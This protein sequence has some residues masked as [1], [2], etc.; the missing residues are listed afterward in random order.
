MHEVQDSLQRVLF[1]QMP[2]QVVGICNVHDLYHKQVNCLPQTG[3][4]RIWVIVD[5]WVLLW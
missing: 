5:H 2:F 4:L 1:P 3:G